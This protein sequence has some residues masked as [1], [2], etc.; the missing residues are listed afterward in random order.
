[1]KQEKFE[2]NATSKVKKEDSAFFCSDEKS[3]NDN[4]EH[5]CTIC[6]KIFKSAKALKLHNSSPRSHVPEDKRFYCYRKKSK[7]FCKGS[8]VAVTLR[9][10][11]DTNFYCGTN[12]ETRILIFVSCPRTTRH[13]KASELIWFVTEEQLKSHNE[14]VHEKVHVCPYEGCDFKTKGKDSQTALFFPVLVDSFW[15]VNP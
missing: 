12:E 3:K 9:M 13:G 5:K 14:K 4:G 10:Y 15:S 8:N 11:C 1:M 7:L 6:D 2:L